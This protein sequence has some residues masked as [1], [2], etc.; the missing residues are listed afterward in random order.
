MQ[1]RVAAVREHVQ[2]DDRVGSG[3]ELIWSNV[4]NYPDDLI[5]TQD[6]WTASHRTG[7]TQVPGCPG[8]TVELGRPIE[9]RQVWLYFR[10][11]PYAPMDFGVNGF[12]RHVR[13]RERYVSR[14]L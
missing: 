2:P 4:Q 8:L 6:A 12:C 7:S 13:H 9:V 14:T 5:E 1:Y 3:Q 11:R 10:G